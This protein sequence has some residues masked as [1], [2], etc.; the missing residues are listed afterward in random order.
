MNDALDNDGYPTEETL[1]KISKWEWSDVFGLLDFLE[2]IWAYAEWGFHRKWGYTNRHLRKEFVLFL[3][4]HTAGWSGNEEIIAAL[5][6]NFMF[7][8]IW[9]VRHD[10]GGHFYFEI[11]PNKIGFKTA[12]ELCKQK[13]VTRQAINKSKD[14]YH[15]LKA[16]GKRFYKPKVE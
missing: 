3:E 2:S 7:F 11:N 16:N 6:K 12:R 10:V 1:E 9:W 8:N 13:E 15:I 14:K 5:R 4:L